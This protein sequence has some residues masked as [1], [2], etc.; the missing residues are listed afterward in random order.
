MLYLITWNKVVYQLQY[1]LQKTQKFIK[2]KNALLKDNWTNGEIKKGKLKNP[3]I[4]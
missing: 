3:R 1:K 4:R 2:T